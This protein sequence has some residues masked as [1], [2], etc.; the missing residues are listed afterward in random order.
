VAATIAAGKA[1]AGFGIQA[2]AAQ[3]G[4]AFLPVISER[5]LFA[6][7]RRILDTPRV[8]AFRA[9]LASSATRAVVRPL[10]GYALEVTDEPAD[11]P[12]ERGASKPRRRITVPE[13]R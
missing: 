13:L 7:R 4:L 2:A 11:S 1:E 8:A 10:P 5:Y 3:F 12:V 9:L 6:C